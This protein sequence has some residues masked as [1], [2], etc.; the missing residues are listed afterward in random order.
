[1]YQIVVKEGVCVV[2]TEM[3]RMA[4]PVARAMGLVG[5]EYQQFIPHYQ[6]REDSCQHRDW[7]SNADDV[8]TGIVSIM[9][10]M[11]FT[12]IGPDKGTTH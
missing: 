9:N 7:S 4:K 11:S 10:D 8:L 2:D 6:H 1:M 5:N 12:N 3:K